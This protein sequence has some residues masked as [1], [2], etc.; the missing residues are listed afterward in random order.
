MV[1]LKEG[2]AFHPYELISSHPQQQVHIVKFQPISD[3]TQAEQLRGKKLYVSEEMLPS[4]SSGEYYTYQLLGLRVVTEQGK[5]IGSVT[6]VFSTGANDI[7]EVM[8]EGGKKGEEVLI[9]A[10]HQVIVAINLDEKK[11]IIRE[12][13]G[14]L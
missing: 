12:L 5:E 8:P 10:I 7:Y 11:I 9:P 3:R 6:H 4:L 1:Y 2:D 13:E 14:L